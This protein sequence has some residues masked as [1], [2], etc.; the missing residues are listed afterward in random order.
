MVRR[1]DDETED[2]VDD[3][4]HVTESRAGKS[5]GEDGTYVGRTAS[6]DAL[7][8]GETGAEARGQSQDR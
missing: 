4:E 1:D 2:D 7:D 6:D 5:G 8:V 3:D